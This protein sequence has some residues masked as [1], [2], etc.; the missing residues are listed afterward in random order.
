MELIGAPELR[1][2]SCSNKVMQVGVE[3][4]PF[5][6][7]FQRLVMAAESGNSFTALLG[8]PPNQAVELLHSSPEIDDSPRGA[9]ISRAAVDSPEPSNSSAVKVMKGEP[10]D[11]CSIPN[12][13]ENEKPLLK[14]KERE[15]KSKGCSKKSKTAGKQMSEDGEELPY[16]HV[17][18]RR[19]QA[20]DSHSL[21][22]RARREK[23]NARMKLLQ[24]LV[25]G[26]SKISG[27]TL[28]L[29][30]IISHVQSLQRQV[31]YLSMR[32][33]AVTPRID[34]NLDSLSAG[35]KF[36][37][38]CN[39]PNMTMPIMWHEAQVND[40]KQ[41]LQWHFESSN[42]QAWVKE[43]NHNHLVTSENSPLKYESSANSALLQS[44]ELKMEL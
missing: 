21:A 26:C 16:V 24:E 12:S 43:V 9:L 13:S 37:M 25:P 28:V 34:F 32:L 10:A 31:E 4:C 44:G 41:Q 38:D 20:T 29:D 7:E 3:N 19:G 8:L 2:T 42:Q 15:T 23:I 33:A 22:E 1:S 27:T 40:N 35:N 5:G 36:M 11:S 39:F 6:G 14:R 18:A 17:R 30:E